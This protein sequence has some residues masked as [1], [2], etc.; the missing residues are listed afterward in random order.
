MCHHLLL[1]KNDQNKYLFSLCFIEEVS[2]LS[3]RYETCFMAR[4]LFTWRPRKL[5]GLGNLPTLA[6]ATTTTIA[7]VVG[8][9][10]YGIYFNRGL[11]NML[12]L[13]LS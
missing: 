4:V 13:N 1:S 5:S 11:M 9:P 10:S 12:K 2:N 7:T 6:A 3:E 8:E